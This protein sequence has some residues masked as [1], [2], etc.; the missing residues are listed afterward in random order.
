MAPG[1]TLRAATALALTL[2]RFPQ[3][4]LRHD[5]LNLL[6]A[7]ALDEP[8]AL[9]GEFRHGLHALRSGESFAGASRFAGGAG[10]HGGPEHA[11]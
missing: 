2:S 7:H 10:R 8:D 5:R 9:A 11:G 4:C 6:D 1:D 3:V